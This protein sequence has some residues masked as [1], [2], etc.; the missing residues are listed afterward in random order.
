[1]V[2]PDSKSDLPLE[3][4]KFNL[5]ERFFLNCD[6]AYLFLFPTI[7]MTKMYAQRGVTR[8]YYGCACAEKK[9]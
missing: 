7:D 1:M 6:V 3:D 5:E 8:R 2:T 4:E 9:P